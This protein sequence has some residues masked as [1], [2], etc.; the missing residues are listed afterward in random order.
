MKREET[1]PSDRARLAAAFAFIVTV[2]GWTNAPAQ[3]S[4]SIPGDPIA[5]RQI[6]V[7]RDCQRCHAVWGSGGTLGP[8]FAVVGA[9]RSLQ[10][11]AG[12]FWNHTPRM[13]ETVRSRGYQWP[14]FTGSELADLISYI[15]YIKLFD[16]P[17][18]PSLGERWF[19]EKG[20]RACHAV[21][22]SGGR[23]AASLD[24]YARY[25]APIVLA[26]GM[27]NHAP[28][29]QQMQRARGGSMPEFTGREIADLQAYIRRA[30]RPHPTQV[31]L[32]Q[33]PDPNRGRA[34][35]S[36]K[37]CARCH[38]SRGTG[39]RLAPS[40]LDATERLRVSE[41][42]GELWN[43]S[44][45][46]AAVMQRE[47]ISF[48][49]FGE[50]EMADVIAFLYYL[51]FY[52]P[53]GDVQ[54]GERVFVEKGCAGCHISDG[55]EGGGPDLANSESVLTPLG[56]ATAMW[57]HAPAMYDLAQLRRADWPRFEGDEMRHLSVYLRSLAERGP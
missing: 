3:T 4:Q 44:F 26:E 41:I 10:E 5:G 23:R 6:F 27:W 45:E 33:P 49:S 42:A 2:A 53:G 17:G 15:Y 38:G 7:E 11:L 57:D 12:M 31:E 46:M 35:F 13:I 14:T 20:C 55:A 50:G 48:P 47:G 40:L 1:R 36:Q 37:Q 34:L 52:D 19:G 16:E 9:G 24:G 8:D 21:G 39:T 29:M 56:L 22:G 54:T 51:R 18:D 25:I 32:L 43:H 28:V 30:S